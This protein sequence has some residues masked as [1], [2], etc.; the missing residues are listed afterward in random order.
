MA[1]DDR[2][3][4]LEINAQAQIAEQCRPK[5]A[6]VLALARALHG[7]FPHRSVDEIHKKLV[8]V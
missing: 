3:L 6:D 5:V 4:V 2:V 7:D 8:A 1:N